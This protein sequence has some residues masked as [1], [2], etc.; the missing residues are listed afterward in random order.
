MMLGF[1]KKLTRRRRQRQGS[2]GGR[3]GSCVIESSDWLKRQQ[4]D[5]ADE[6]P[7]L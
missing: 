6:L 7:E 5:D 1:L 3:R 4:V 2:S